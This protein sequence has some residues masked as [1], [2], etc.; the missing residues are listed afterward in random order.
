MVYRI[1]P[2]K[3]KIL[4]KEKPLR[5]YRRASSDSPKRLYG[6][7]V[8]E[9]ELA[10]FFE[11]S[12]L[13]ALS[14]RKKERGFLASLKKALIAFGADLRKGA[15]TLLTFAHRTGDTFAEWR[16]K[17]RE[18][19]EAKKSLPTLTP[20]LAGA[21]SGIILVCFVSGIAVLYKLFI[22]DYFGRYTTLV[23]PSV[24]GMSYE[25]ARELIDEA[26]Y[27]IRVS[28]EY[29]MNIPSGEVIKQEP[30][31]GVLRKIYKGEG[32][33]SLSVVVSRGKR[34]FTMPD[35]I[36]AL[37]RD[38]VLELKNMG[39]A[40]E[41]KRVYSSTV[42][43]GLVIASDPAPNESFYEGQKVTI[44]ISLGKKKSY[45][46]LP[47]TP[48]NIN[49]KIPSLIGKSLGEAK[50]ILNEYELICGN[51]YAVKSAM[52]SGTVVSQS[53]SANSD[54]SGKGQSVDIYVSS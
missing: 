2:S 38:A 45:E 20:V 9:V 7:R 39:A 24:V 26:Y 49:K 54:I 34:D 47:S 43:S 27:D 44:E 35:I 19:R 40:V 28:Y 11:L 48:A 18:K 21:L 12:K 3:N 31:G 37:G 42:R 16:R 33:P 13:E 22:K 14:R 52:P 50:E 30:S 6:Y 1:R 25:S 15:R 46:P 41:E 23:V 17:R 36:G 32:L 4:Q 53:P 8:D 5:R 10:L 29:D 51:I